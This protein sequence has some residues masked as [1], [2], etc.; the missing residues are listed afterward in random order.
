MG[1]FLYSFTDLVKSL[2]NSVNRNVTTANRY[3]KN[4]LF[5]FKNRFFSFLVFLVQPRLFNEKEARKNIKERKTIKRIL[6]SAPLTRNELHV[7][8]SVKIISS[9]T[10]LS[11]NHQSSSGNLSK[12]S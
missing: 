4:L 1:D 11:S 5:I 8:V 12:K 7:G 2:N 9:K 3:R 6:R 10:K